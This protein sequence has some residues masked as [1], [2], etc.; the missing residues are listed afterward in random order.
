VSSAASYGRN[1]WG[2]TL[3]EVLVALS[4]VTVGLMALVVGLQ[5]AIAFVEAGRQQTTAVFLA[6]QRLEQIKA[7][8]LWDFDGVTAARFPAEN[9]VS[10]YPAYRRTVE[11]SPRPA[12]LPDALRV[13]VTVTYHPATTASGAP[14]ERT[15]TLATVMSRRR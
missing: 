12:G 14:A 9:P 5:Q 3:A 6:Q 2:F 15:V 4:I 7:S 11:V 8:A 10:D 1:P 13:Q